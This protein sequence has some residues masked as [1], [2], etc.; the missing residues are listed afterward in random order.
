MD[1]ISSL[2]SRGARG[3]DWFGELQTVACLFG[4][5]SYPQQEEEPVP[6]S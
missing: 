1:F 3:K 2:T 4:P 5:L 6:K